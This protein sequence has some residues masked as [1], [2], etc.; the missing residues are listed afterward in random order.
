[1]E[2]NKWAETAARYGMRPAAFERLLV[3][4]GWIVDGAFRTEYVQG[5]QL[6]PLAAGFLDG[7]FWQLGAR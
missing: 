2:T 1:M 6:T 7:Y 4:L 3:E 5:G